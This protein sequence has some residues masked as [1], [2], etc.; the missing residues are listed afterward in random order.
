MGETLLVNGGA[1]YRLTEKWTTSLQANLRTSPHDEFKGEEVPSTGG[2]WIYL[3][4]GVKVQASPNTS[5][6][7]HIQ[8][9]LYQRVNEVNLVPRYGFIMGVSHVF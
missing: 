9:P 3:T 2:T 4:P 7:T 6:Y 8:F 1:A 5:L